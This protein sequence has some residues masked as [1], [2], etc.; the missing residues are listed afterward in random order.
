MTLI[1]RSTHR[2]QR[3]PWVEIDVH[4]YQRAPWVEI[5]VHRYQRAPWVEIDVHRY[6]RAPWVEIE[7][8]IL[9]SSVTHY[10][11]TQTTGKKKPA[12]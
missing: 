12:T 3:A 9:A 5:D 1:P 4:R 8:K 6:Q 7:A 2:Y 11:N 10:D